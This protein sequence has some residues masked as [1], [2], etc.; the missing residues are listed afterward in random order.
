MPRL[1]GKLLERNRIGSELQKMEQE[2]K[3]VSLLKNIFL[4]FIANF[5]PRA[6]TFFMVPLYTYCLS[7][8]EY[9]TVDLLITSVQLLLPFLTIQVQDAMLRFSIESTN[10]KSDV[11]T[12]GMRIVLSGGL[13][14]FLL[15]VGAIAF[16]LVKLDLIYVVIFFVMY[17]LNA[18]RSIAS[19]FCRGIDKIGILTTSN[20]LLTIV[21]VLCNLLFLL[22]FKWG[23]L[24]YLLSLCL[25]NLVCAC[26]LFFGAKLYQYV[27][28]SL[29][30]R[31]LTKKIIIF[32]IPMVFSALSWWINTSMDK[33][34]LGYFCGTSAVGLL[35]IAYK[36]PSVLS[37]FG[38][39]I[40][41]GYS[42]SAIK[43]FDKNDTDGFLGKSYSVINMF[44]VLICTVLMFANVYVSK[45]LFS[46]DFF[47]A[48]KYVP[49][50]LISA[51]MSQLSLTCEQYYISL[52]KTNIISITATVGAT[53]NIV[54]NILL[55]PSLEAY[56]VAIATAFS[57][58]VVWVIRYA[59]LTK[60]IKLRHNFM[61]ECISYFLL[62][63]QVIFAYNGN[64]FIIYQLIIMVVIMLLYAKQIR[65]I[66]VASFSYIIEKVSR[67]S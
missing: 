59:I 26:I 17:L 13:L 34:I 41:N 25:G 47:A 33:Y 48:W 57:F 28:L 61:L 22:I 5:M 37:L 24:G 58:F 46:K 66:T 4:F 3:S 63:V 39:T 44:F 7:T 20:I 45:I 38:T 43:D 2:K 1:C 10:S 60:Y 30:D 14:L 42:I 31:L 21:T 8:E 29:L 12:I 19:Y 15:C 16:D 54:L 50:L 27:K 52:K 49:P 32:S 6:I 9:G 65:E 53:I 40:A 67:R 51:L 64:D 55:V 62:I 18:F 35:A 23:V 36:I 56:G 11:F